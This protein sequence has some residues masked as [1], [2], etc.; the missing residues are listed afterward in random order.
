MGNF[1]KKSVGK[2]LFQQA[3]WDVGMF[4]Y[5]LMSYDSVVEDIDAALDA[6][7][8]AAFQAVHYMGF[9]DP[10]K[11]SIDDLND[12][13]YAVVLLSAYKI[14]LTNLRAA[15]LQ[16]IKLLQGPK[17]DADPKEIERIIDSYDRLHG[18]IVRAYNHD[19]KKHRFYNSVRSYN[20]GFEEACEI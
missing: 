1:D 12:D 7:M 8:G 5:A 18:R 14:V 11:T 6:S 10:E 20:I 3:A 9:S 16:R 13:D 15:C 17:A 2:R 4:R 19:D